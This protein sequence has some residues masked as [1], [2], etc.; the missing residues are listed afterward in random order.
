MLRQRLQ[1]LCKALGSAWDSLRS[2]LTKVAPRYRFVTGRKRISLPELLQALGVLAKAILDSTLM[3]TRKI[4]K[5]EL[6]ASRCYVLPLDTTRILHS[7]HALYTLIFA[8]SSSSR[9]WQAQSTVQTACIC[10]HKPGLS[11]STNRWLE[12]CMVAK[13]CRGGK[14][15]QKKREAYHE[16]HD[17]Y[18]LLHTRGP[19][20][21]FACLQGLNP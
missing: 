21:V 5:W 3:T 19:F 1:R 18:F 10:L 13:P 6:I 15:S 11:A 20:P 2:K 9:L 16:T 4:R 8:S 7:R 12:L 14:L 17:I